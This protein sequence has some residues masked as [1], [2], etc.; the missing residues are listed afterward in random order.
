MSC[1]I[2]FS[3]CDALD[4]NLNSPVQVSPANLTVNDL[5]NRIQLDMG[6]IMDNA[7]Y[8]PASTA[9]MISN[10]SAYQYEN[11]H[12]QQSFNGFWTNI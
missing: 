11:A 3:A 5:Y 6:F 10:T 12:N 7:W 2:G 1:I 8:Q 9:R 4:E